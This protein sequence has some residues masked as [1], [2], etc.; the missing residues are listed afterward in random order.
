MY[1]R[2][3]AKFSDIEGIRQSFRDIYEIF[4]YFSWASKWYWKSLYLLCELKHTSN[5]FDPFLIKK[6]YAIYDIFAIQFDKKIYNYYLF[7]Y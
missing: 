1:T 5:E 4:S 6:K 7:F 3:L 2:E